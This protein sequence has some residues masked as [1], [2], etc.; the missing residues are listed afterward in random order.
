M[1]TYPT[2]II[3][4]LQLN[5][6]QWISEQET[7]SGD[8]ADTAAGQIITKLNRRISLLFWENSPADIE[9]ALL[10]EQDAGDLFGIQ[11]QVVLDISGAGLWQGLRGGV[12]GEAD[13]QVG[14]GAVGHKLLQLLSEDTTAN[15]SLLSQKQWG[16][17]SCGFWGQGDC[18]VHT[19]CV[20]YYR[21]LKNKYIEAFIGSLYNSFKCT[22]LKIWFHT[23]ML[24]TY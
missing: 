3:K 10:F 16:M 7:T 12:S 11:E 4:I 21:G 20:R 5:K 23:E 19:S 8:N 18:A 24:N 9:I 13:S 22:L 1:S 6:W 14:Q 2:Y 15:N 17:E